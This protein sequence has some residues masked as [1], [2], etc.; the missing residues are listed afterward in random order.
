MFKGEAASYRWVETV[1]EWESIRVV[2]GGQKGMLKGRKLQQGPCGVGWGVVIRSRCFLSHNTGS[3]KK[4]GHVGR[5]CCQ[6]R[7]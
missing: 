5:T 2:G 6:V 7:I 1:T 4:S 3:N